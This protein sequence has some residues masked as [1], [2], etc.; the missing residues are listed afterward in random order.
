[1]LVTRGFDIVGPLD[2]DRLLE[3]LYAVIEQHQGMRATV[4]ISEHGHPNLVIH[5][6]ATQRPLVLQA[7]T[8]R[9]RGQF[10]AYARSAGRADMTSLWDPVRGP[11]Y[12][13]RLLRWSA[14]EHIL[15]GTFDHLAFDDRAA[16]LFFHYLWVG[17]SDPDGTASGTENTGTSIDLATSIKMERERYADRATSVNTEYW[18]RLYA[19][20]PEDPSSDRNHGQESE[21]EY[22]C[23]NASLELNADSAADIRLAAAR[24]EVSMFTAYAAVFAWT[25]FN[26]IRREKLAIYVPLDNRRPTCGL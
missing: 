6:Q 25:A 1:M 15:L 23:D 13:L 5:P 10:E 8:A 16:E 12:R 7:V 18:A 14:K 9:S 4:N 17:Y 22:E 24:A 21:P 11:L 20:I 26:H 2:V 3:A 19:Q